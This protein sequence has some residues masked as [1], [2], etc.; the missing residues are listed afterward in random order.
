M[1]VYNVCMSVCVCVCA[2]QWIL[3]MKLTRR[4]LKT[5]YRRT[6]H[7]CWTELK[8]ALYVVVS[9]RL[10]CST[11]PLGSCTI[12]YFLS[13][14]LFFLSLLC[15]FLS[16]IRLF[17]LTWLLSFF[18]SFLPSFI[19]PSLLLSL[20]PSLRPSLPASLPPFPHSLLPF[21]FSSFFLYTCYLSTDFEWII[22]LRHQWQC[23]YLT[24]AI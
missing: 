4:C 1:C 17:I 19:P 20:P 10:C 11:T 8:A 5:T 6:W 3:L 23:A 9:R 12:L 14:V 18:V 15:S 21:F 2:V 16:F 7:S 13:F 22:V 24:A